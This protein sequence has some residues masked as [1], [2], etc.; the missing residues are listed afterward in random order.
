LLIW[1]HPARPEIKK[2][3]RR[4]KKMATFL[5]LTA[6][7]LTPEQVAA[8]QSLGASRFLEAADVLLAD[9]VASLRNC[10]ADKDGIVALAYKLIDAIK[11]QSAGQDS[12]LFVHLPCGSPALMW[13]FCGIVGGAVP[14]LDCVFNAVF[15]H[16]V[17]ESVE[18]IQPDGSVVKNSVFR[19]QKFIV[20]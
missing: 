8:A 17:R 19:F 12:L 6:H 18:T 1:N 9:T 4:N 3:R 16:S 13:E 11:L 2:R 7:A 5:N 15:S 10:P 14:L 20:L